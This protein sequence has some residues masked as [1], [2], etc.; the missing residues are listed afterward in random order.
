MDFNLFNEYHFEIAT[1]TKA[2]S[3]FFSK[4]RPLVFQNQIDLTLHSIFSDEELKLRE[5]L[6]NN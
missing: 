1:D 3:D 4:N 6:S 5:E 2:F